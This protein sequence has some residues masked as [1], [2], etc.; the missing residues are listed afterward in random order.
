[1]QDAGYITFFS[2]KKEVVLS[3]RT[4][5]YALMN[6]KMVEI[7]TTGGNIYQTRMKF[8]DVENALGSN[9]VKIHRGCIVSAFAI[10]EVSDEINLNNGESLLYTRRKKKEIISNI[11]QIQKTTIA[12][13]NH[14]GIPVT[15]EEYIEHYKSF[16]NMPF[17]FT[18]IEL[19]LMMKQRRLTGFFVTVMR[20]WHFWK[21]FLWISLSVILSEAFSLIW[22]QNGC[23]LTKGQLCTVKPLKSLTTARRLIQT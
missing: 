3:I 8:G 2:N 20:R 19:T 6:G 1:M 14:D 7:H 5:I 11:K 21:K 13:F 22:T 23:V 18:D 12:N 15:D 17:A 4:V 9:F 16:E 10:H